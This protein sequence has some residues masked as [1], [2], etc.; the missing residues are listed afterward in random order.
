MGLHGFNAHLHV[1][2]TLRVESKFAWAGDACL[3]LGVQALAWS[4]YL[5]AFLWEISPVSPT[6]DGPGGG[7]ASVI[8][9]NFCVIVL[10]HLFLFLFYFIA[11]VHLFLISLLLS[12]PERTIFLACLHNVLLRAS[13]EEEL[14]LLTYSLLWPTAFFCRL[15]SYRVS[16]MEFLYFFFLLLCVKL[17][18]R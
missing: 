18:K 1:S 17:F 16:Y 11:D 2:H 10:C 13:S 8:F 15:L 5:P 9:T 7:G 14:K 4:A 3:G 6:A 12:I